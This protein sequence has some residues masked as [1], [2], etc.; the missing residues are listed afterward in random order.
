MQR[1]EVGAAPLSE[2]GNGMGGHT[3]SD[4]LKIS[5]DNS[6]GSGAWEN[7]LEASAMWELM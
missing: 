6:A 4:S 2:G 7:A 3:S 1:K 5:Q